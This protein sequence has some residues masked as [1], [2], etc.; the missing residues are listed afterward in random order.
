MDR[1]P[2]LFRISLW[3]DR[4][5]GLERT[6]KSSQR[7]QVEE[8]GRGEDETTTNSGIFWLHISSFA[9]Y[10]ALIG[11]LLVHREEQDMRGLLFFSVAMAVHFLVN[12]YGLRQDH[13]DTYRDVGRWVLAAAILIGWVAGLATSVS[14]AAIGVLFAFLAGGVVL[15]VL[16][17]E[18]PEERQSRFS[19][20]VFGAATYTVLLLL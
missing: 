17:E 2:C 10:N 6:V 3:V 14:E 1:T 16:K 13:K 15:N 19:P 18:L 7:R 11:Y 9:I 5:Y 12:D 4:V 8:P 20:F